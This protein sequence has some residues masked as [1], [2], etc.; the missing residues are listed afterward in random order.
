[1][2]PLGVAG[3]APARALLAAPTDEDAPALRFEGP[4]PHW[5]LRGSARLQPT[6]APRLLAAALLPPPE[7]RPANGEA[8]DG[9][10]QQVALAAAAASRQAAA[11][12]RALPLLR[13]SSEA[14]AGSQSFLEHAEDQLAARLHVENDRLREENGRLRGQEVELRRESATLH[15]GD[16]A[17]HVEDSMLRQEQ[18]R[19]RRMTASLASALAAARRRG[20][21]ALLGT[22]EHQQL[23]LN[24]DTV[25]SLCIVLGGL[26]LLAFLYVSCCHAEDE[27][28]DDSDDD[29]YDMDDKRWAVLKRPGSE[30]R[31]G[32]CCCCSPCWWCNRQVATFCLGICLVTF[33]GGAVLWKFNIIQPILSQVVMYVY[34]AVVLTAF[35]GLVMSQ[36]WKMVW[37][38]VTY[39]GKDLGKV[40]GMFGG[41]RGVGKNAK[42]AGYKIRE[43]LDDGMLNNSYEDPRLKGKRGR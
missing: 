16:E 32:W 1:M 5:R 4:R 18:T 36:L 31:S 39:I 27:D 19:L 20:P 17:L 35:I 9:L 3:A 11:D 41:F 2:L 15:L 13:L 8:L 33:V 28:D 34:I 25:M 10:R 38:M 30:K 40:K 21:A 43:F 7:A 23:H 14:L 29:D 42:N 26:T 6:A 12:E 37:K 24:H 22:G